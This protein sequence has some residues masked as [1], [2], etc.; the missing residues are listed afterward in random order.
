[1]I[2]TVTL[3]PSI[4][5]HLWLNQSVVS[6]KN[7]VH[8]TLP[9]AGGKG[10]NVSIVLHHMGVASTALGFWGGFTGSYIKSALKKIGIRQNFVTI[11]SDTRIN[12]KL[13]WT[14]DEAELPGSSPHICAQEY[15]LF[16]QRLE[17]LTKNDILVLSGSI[18]ACLPQDLYTQIFSLVNPGVKIFV[19][20]S[21]DAL[22]SVIQ[23][24]PFAIK[25]N[26]YEL[27]ELLG[28][29]ATKDLEKNIQF[30]HQLHENGVENVIVSMADK[31]AILVNAQ[32][33][34]HAISPK[35]DVHNSVG[36]GD[37]VVAGFL[38]AYIK[39]NHNSQEMLHR[40]VACGSATAFSGHLAS[41][42]FV[43]S[44]YQKI[45]LKRV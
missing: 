31:G 23:A 30:A 5:Y 16:L 14:E 42:E 35:G 38:A 1:M 27:A 36:A 18:P 3:N 26:H 43:D 37:S 19:D 17:I 11:E 8:R 15:E 21:G 40:G 39:D 12:V 4:D 25:P 13:H 32:G 7:K 41:K 20:T 2:Y 6:G 22:K 33:T 9:T 28:K 44:L 34:Y 45:I 29:P 10:I 24:K